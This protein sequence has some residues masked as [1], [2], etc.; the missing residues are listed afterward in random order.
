VDEAAE[1]D[2]WDVEA[3]AMLSFLAHEAGATAGGAS[4]GSGV[5]AAAG[6]GGAGDTPL[7]HRG[8]WRVPEVQGQ[9]CSVPAM[10]DGPM[11]DHGNTLIRVPHWSCCGALARDAVCAPAPP[12]A[13]AA[14]GPGAV[15]VHE[16]AV[17]VAAGMVVTAGAAPPDMLRV[18][19]HVKLKR[20]VHDSRVLHG[21]GVG[22]II[23]HTVTARDNLYTV[24]VGG[25]VSSYAPWE[26]TWVPTPA[27]MVPPA[28]AKA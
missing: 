22:L 16:K 2:A 11:C 3:D 9:Y 1:E 23:A 20:P 13:P 4:P 10:M 26:I 18:G 5:V 17:A 15:V 14:A 7:G 19:H 24:I 25:E 27:V 12:A 8:T 28:A 21:D 6:A